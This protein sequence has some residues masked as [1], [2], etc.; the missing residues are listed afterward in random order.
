MVLQ[1][2]PR[3]GLP[4][5]IQPRG[6]VIRNQR[7]SHLALGFTLPMQSALL[8][9][10]SEGDS[11]GDLRAVHNSLETEIVVLVVTAESP[12]TDLSKDGMS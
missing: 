3:F 10:V 11:G 12:V 5:T 2:C 9:S 7:V 1:P 4:P 6:E 8:T